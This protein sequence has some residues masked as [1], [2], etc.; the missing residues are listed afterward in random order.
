ML[1]RK[2]LRRTNSIRL[3]HS[4]NFL[5]KNR[6]KLLK[7]HNIKYLLDIGANTGQFAYYTRKAGYTNQ[8]ISFEPVS[9]VFSILEKFAENDPLWKTVNIAIGDKDGETEINISSNLF[10]NSILDILPAHVNSAPE[11]AYSGKEIVRINRLDTIIDQYTVDLDVTFLKTDAQGYEAK[12]LKGAGRSLEKIK[13]LQLELSIIELYR[14]EI[15]FDEML[16]LLK[17]K[18]FALYSLEPGFYDLKTGRLLQVDAIFYR[19]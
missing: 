18:G 1:V 10:S 12:I 16:G 14:D 3:N 19:S 9:T 11:A 17:N 2:I 6:V 5:L 15:L 4:G 7:H 8:I 13:G